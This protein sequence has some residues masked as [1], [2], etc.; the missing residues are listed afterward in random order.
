MRINMNEAAKLIR[1]C[2]NAVILL[3]ESPDG[4]TMGSGFALCRALR[5]IGKKANVLCSDELPPKFS[6]LYDCYK[7]WF[8][9]NSPSGSPQGKNTFITDIINLLP[10]LPDWTCQGRTKAIKPAK[11]MDKSEA[12]IIEY[13][14][15]DWMNPDYTGADINQ[16]CRPKLKN[17]YNGLLRVPVAAAKDASD[18]DTTDIDTPFEDAND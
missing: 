10:T 18:D 1:E 9:R 6:F 13:D 8:K 3:H 17:T 12:L 14:L 16:K 7:S 11:R 5:S 4:D 2:G 15:K